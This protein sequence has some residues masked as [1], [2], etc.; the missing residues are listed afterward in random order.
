MTSHT[1]SAP[2]DFPAV[3]SRRDFAIGTVIALSMG[4]VFAALGHGLSL[5]VT[6]IPCLGIVWLVFAGMH[7]QRIELP[8]ADRFAPLFF[9]ALAV[10]FLHFAEEY[11]SGFR[12]AF[13]ELYGGAPYDGDLFVVFNMTAYAVFAIAC[14]LAFYRG[15][16]F[17]IVPVLFFIMY[18]AMCNAISHTFWAVRA[19]N[20]WPGLITAQLYWIL[21]P[22][23]LYA[24][25]RSK[26]QTAL[27]GFGLAAILIPLLAAFAGR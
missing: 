14:V 20:Y 8:G 27:V 17:L 24:L 3:I 6:F 18:G 21:G 4:G 16:R 11:V 1:F 22:A 23:L 25:L 12:L 13:P 15:V 9:V 26:A 2:A 19:H 5:W 7:F 10:Q